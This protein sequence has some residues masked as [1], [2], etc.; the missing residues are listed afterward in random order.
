MHALTIWCRLFDHFPTKI[1]SQFMRCKQP[2]NN[3]KK[4]IYIEMWCSYRMQSK[5][6]AV[7]LFGCQI[8]HGL[9]IDFALNLA[10]SIT[11]EVL[12]SVW[13]YISRTLSLHEIKTSHRGRAATIVL[14]EERDRFRER[15]WIVESNGGQCLCLHHKSD[16]CDTPLVSHKFK[17][18]HK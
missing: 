18:Q 11:L 15:N 4:N 14:E 17:R 13:F 3:R 6:V 8:Y 2:I 7:I 12:I 10:L 9:S 1:S 16:R 5:C